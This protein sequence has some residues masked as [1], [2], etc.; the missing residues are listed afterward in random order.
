[1]TACAALESLIGVLCNYLREGT[2]PQALDMGCLVHHKG[3]RCTKLSSHFSPCDDTHQSHKMC[4]GSTGRGA[5]V[6]SLWRLARV[7]PR[8]STKQT[9]S[10]MVCVTATRKQRSIDYFSLYSQNKRLKLTKHQAAQNV[11]N[12]NHG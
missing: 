8:Q 9:A 5:A 11:R 4:R 3:C 7:E 12:D 1:M 2:Q 6:D 10:T